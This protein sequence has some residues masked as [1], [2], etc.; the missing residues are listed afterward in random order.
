MKAVTYFLMMLLVGVPSA[1][2]AADGTGDPA[3]KALVHETL[4][5][6][7][8]EGPFAA[9][10]RVCGEGDPILSV[11]SLND[12]MRQVYWKERDLTLALAFGRAGHQ[13]ASTTAA[14]MLGRD[15]ERMTQLLSAAKAFTYDIASFTW[16]GWDEKG[17]EIAET[18]LKEGLA[19][20]R[21]NLRLAKRLAKGP[22]ALSR[23]YWMLGAQEMASSNYASSIKAFALATEQGR[24]AGSRGEELL[25]RSFGDLVVLLGS[26]DKQA[27]SRQL[28]ASLSELRKE[29][30]GEF[31]AAQV[32]TARRVFEPRSH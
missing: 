11:R 14:R 27:A 4:Q 29:K 19:A 32:E 1:A 30:D 31:F 21:E 7:S 10:A 28:E 6:Y 12:L 5:V 17:I 20:A 25:A 9:V 22:L 23:A 16:P 8:D 13:H 26:P 15:P 24:A 18:H 3:R 2:L